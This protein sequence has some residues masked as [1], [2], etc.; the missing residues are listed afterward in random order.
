[1]T[2]IKIVGKTP[3][4][5]SKEEIRSVFH[6]TNSVLSYHNL[7]PYNNTIIV[8]FTNKDFGKTK[9]G[10]KSV[11]VAIYKASKIWIDVD[12]SIIIPNT[13]VLI[14]NAKIYSFKQED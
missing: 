7:K 9:T 12:W 4:N 5:L 8:K 10:S 14:K 3:R 6:A 11:G 1:M 13:T 2:E